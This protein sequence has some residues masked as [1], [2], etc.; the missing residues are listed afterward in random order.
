MSGAG[1]TARF[2]NFRRATLWR[3]R[4]RSD[5]RAWGPPDKGQDRE[6]E[7]FLDAVKTGGPMPIPLVTLAATT[8][9]TLAVDRSIRAGGP[10][11]VP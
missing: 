2:D 8:A 5:R 10:V 7:C 3:G 1:C 4:R 11:V 9:A 6:L